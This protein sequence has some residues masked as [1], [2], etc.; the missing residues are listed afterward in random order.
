[1]ST[2][3]VN[4]AGFVLP[5]PINELKNHALRV[6]GTVC[7]VIGIVGLVLP[8]LPGV[9]FLILAGFCFEAIG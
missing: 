5:E 7:A 1:M 2:T 8:V 9:P 4:D 3:T 6:V